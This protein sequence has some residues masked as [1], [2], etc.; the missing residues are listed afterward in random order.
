MF[1]RFFISVAIVF[2]FFMSNIFDMTLQYM[3]CEKI[4][5]NYYISSFLI[6]QCNNNERYSF[7]KYYFIWPCFIFFIIF[8]PFVCFLFM[9][10]NKKRLFEDDVIVK[11]G[12]LLHGYTSKTFYW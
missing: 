7:W 1:E 4:D 2:I 6:E 10:Q 5:E 11:I 8:I 12:F 3:N 9:F